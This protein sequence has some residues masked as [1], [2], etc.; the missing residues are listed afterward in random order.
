MRA[1]R[2]R[3]GSGRRHVAAAGAKATVGGGL[4]PFRS[5]APELPASLASTAVG[6]EGG[7]RGAPSGDYGAYSRGRRVWGR[8]W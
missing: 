3:A 8:A 5:P 2:L 4:P 1:R 7:D 6:L